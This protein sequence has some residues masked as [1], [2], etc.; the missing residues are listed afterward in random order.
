MGSKQ[1]TSLSNIIDVVNDNMFKAISEV[2]T[3]QEQTCEVKQNINIQC[4]GEC[5]KIYVKQVAQ[6][7]CSFEGSALADLQSELSNTVATTLDTMATQG[8]ESEIEFLALG[9]S[10]Q[11]M[12]TDMK[13]FIQNTFEAEIENLATSNCGQNL[14]IEQD[15]TVVVYGS[16]DEI[17]IEQYA[18]AYGIASCLSES[19]L[20]TIIENETVNDVLQEFE[21]QQKATL[22][23]LGSLFNIWV[24]LLLGGA[25]LL[26]GG[27]T[28]VL[29][30]Y[31]TPILIGAAIL[32]V[33]AVVNMII[34][35]QKD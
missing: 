7:V 27:G 32:V 3:D 33:L 17:K 11:T 10:S 28:T 22:T 31:K 18:Q 23:G 35:A 1:S 9:L 5:G 4:V 30:E 29:K 25:L 8:Q 15:G 2:K 34:N 12:N 14:S 16:A 19:T 24:V 13:T 26:F 6:A 21:Q 20:K